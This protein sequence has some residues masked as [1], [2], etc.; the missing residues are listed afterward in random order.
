M[1][2]E[3]LQEIMAKEGD[4]KQVV[5]RGIEV[6]LV[7]NLIHLNWEASFSVPSNG[8]KINSELASELGEKHT[9]VYSIDKEDNNIVFEL[10]ARRKQDL[11]PMELLCFG[12]GQ[13]KTYKTIEYVI[14]ACQQL[15]DDL[16]YIK[17]KNDNSKKE[18]QAFRD[19]IAS[20][21]K[22]LKNLMSE[23]NE[24]WDNIQD[25]DFLD[26]C[27]PFDYSFDEIVDTVN[28]WAESV[29]ENKGLK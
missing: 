2:R 13:G 6:K 21:I 20:K 1:K 29:E 28:E 15:I 18:Q 24:C 25:T 23:I 8:L 16:M 11:T 4:K 7:R 19:S 27:Y 14:G 17:S 10:K 12:N 22:N 5:Y 3:E 26:K 9:L